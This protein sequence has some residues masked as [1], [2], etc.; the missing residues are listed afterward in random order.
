M[1]EIVVAITAA[2]YSG[3]KGAAAMLQSSIKQLYDK[4]GERLEINLMSVYPGEDK[5]QIPY[6]FINIV[7]CKPEQLLFVAF[8]MAVLYKI[9]SWCPP[10]KK[11]LL[12]NKILK[13]YKNTDLVLDEAGISFVD[14]RGFIMNTYAFVCAAVPM[15]VGT[16]VVKYSQAMGTFKNPYNRFLAKWILPKLKLVCAR[17]QGTYDNLAGIGITKNVVLCADGAFTMEDSPYWTKEVDRVCSEDPFY[18]DEVVGL[19]IS[20]VVEKKCAKMGIP[21]ADIMVEFIDS[22]NKKGKP[23][24]LIANAARINSEKTRNNDLMICDKVYE[25]VKDKDMVRWYHKEMDAE[26]IRSYI[27]KCQVLVASRFH[28]MIGSLEQKVPVLL[29]G[30]SHKYQEV[31][32]MFGLGQYAI[33]FSRL[34]SDDLMASFEEFMKHKDE[35]KVSIEENYDKVMESSRENIRLTSEIIDEIMEHPKK[36]GKLFDYNNPEKYLGEHVACRKGYAADETIRANAASGG[37]VTALLVHLLKTGQIDGAWVTKTAI[38]DGKLTY[39]TFIATTEEELRS[40]SSSIYMQMPLLKHLDIVRKFQGKVAVVLTPC[41]LNSLTK[42]MEKEPELKEKIVLKLGLYCSGNHSDKATLLS[43]KHSKVSLEGAK[44]LYYRRGHWRGQSAVVYEDGSEKTFSYTKTICA[45]KNAYF[46]EQGSCMLCQDQYGRYSDISFGDIW[47]K[48]MKGNPI[49]HTSCIIRN[50]KA[51]SMFQS[52]VDAG[53]IVADRIN[54]TKMVKSQ[55]R[56]LVFKFNLAKA[57]KKYY[58]KHGKNIAINA[59]DPCKWNHKLAFYL[60]RKN[61]K[62]SEEHYDKL[63]KVPVILIYYYMCFI[64]VLLS[65]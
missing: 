55:K 47:L 15:L 10:I 62:Y 22:L 37:M 32:D 39:D 35:I 64:R 26:E 8:P 3:N 31:L 51:L 57:K 56:A 9:F 49:K 34:T 2:S 16:P 29:V 20:S 14:S 41:L 5:E 6:D 53:A 65:F 46:F 63:S 48:E 61:K 60:A 24:L 18:N 28:A 4:Y 45:Y 43:M 54:D 42:M 30:W 1:R 7:S 17:G 21:Y 38:R 11:L 23:V 13:A 27:G 36:K 33:D 40:A 19:S 12:K 44:R 25:N 52:A 59:D 58:A 50:E